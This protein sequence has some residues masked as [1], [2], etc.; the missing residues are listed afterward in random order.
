MTYTGPVVGDDSDLGNLKGAMAVGF[1]HWLREQKG[2]DA[3]GRAV[4]R[5][6]EDEKSLYALDRPDLGMLPSSWYPA[7]QLHSMLEACI[8]EFRPEEMDEVARSAGDAIIANVMTG[9]QKGL[10]ALLMNPD[11]YAKYIQRIWRQ[12]SDTGT[13][14]ITSSPGQH[15]SRISGWKGH[16]PL[17]CKM[18][19]YGK[20]R[21]YRTMGCQ[22]PQV[23]VLG[24]DPARGCE[25]TVRWVE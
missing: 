24:C 6:G 10:F 14:E 17:L 18:V 1:L 13:V 20:L 21:I 11:R 12:N 9:L 7:R 19:V 15:H 4:D 5:L 3:V 16:H 22:D 25:S 8:A 23:Q 2:E